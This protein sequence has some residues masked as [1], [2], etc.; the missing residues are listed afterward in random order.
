VKDI[1]QLPIVL[2][3]VLL[4]NDIV[5]TSGAGDIGAAS[6]KLEAQLNNQQKSDQDT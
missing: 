2:K 1:E 3:G 4:P 6:A 5:L